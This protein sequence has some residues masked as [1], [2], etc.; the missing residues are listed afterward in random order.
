MQM[1]MQLFGGKYRSRT[2][3]ENKRYVCNYDGCDKRFFHSTAL[4]RHQTTAHGA[5]PKGP[6]TRGKR[7]SHNID[8]SN[9]IGIQPMHAASATYDVQEA[10]SLNNAISGSNTDETHTEYTDIKSEKTFESD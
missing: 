10:D 5:A 4:N 1:A 7:R 8:Y 6:G 2:D 9:M 3:Y